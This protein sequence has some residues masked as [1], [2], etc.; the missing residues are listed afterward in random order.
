MALY[1]GIFLIFVLV[2]SAVPVFQAAHAL[3]HV[4]HVDMLGPAQVHDNQGEAET[5][6]DPDRI[7]LDCLALTAF[8]IILFILRIFFFDQ[9]V[10][11]PLPYLKPRHILRSL[12]FPFLTRAPPRA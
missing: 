12:S 5:D 6:A 7:C 3:T 10:Q 2:L 11:K 1:K 8:S 4:A 9:M